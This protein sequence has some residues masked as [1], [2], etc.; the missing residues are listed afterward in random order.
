MPSHLVHRPPAEQAST[1]ENG[2]VRNISMPRTLIRNGLLAFVITAGSSLVQSSDLNQPKNKVSELETMMQERLTCAI[3]S[4]AGVN[5][6]AMFGHW[7]A[8]K[9]TL[10]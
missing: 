1:E 10:Y 9:T 6:Y 5:L 8:A 2:L 3:T 4:R 7:E